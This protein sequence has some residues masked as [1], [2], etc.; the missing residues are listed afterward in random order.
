MRVFYII[1]LFWFYYDIERS[2]FFL[3]NNIGKILVVNK[4]NNHLIRSV[5]FIYTW[6]KSIYISLSFQV[7]FSLYP[8]F[9]NCLFY[10]F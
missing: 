6:S 5:L 10:I 2:F 4:K 7:Y 8:L 9:H 1:I 3:F